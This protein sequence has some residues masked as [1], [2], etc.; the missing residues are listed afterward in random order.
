MKKKGRGK[1]WRERDKDLKIGKEN[2]TGVQKK[3]TNQSKGTQKSTKDYVHK[4]SWNKDVTLHIE[5]TLG[6]WAQNNQHQHILVK[7]LG[8]EKRNNFGSPDK[9]KEMI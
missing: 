5:K 4:T 6:K 1:D 2:A 7:L 9:K 3:N 8:F